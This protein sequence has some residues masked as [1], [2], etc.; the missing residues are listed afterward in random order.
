MIYPQ[1]QCAI[2]DLKFVA[3]SVIYMFF[4]FL[5]GREKGY[6]FHIT[7]KVKYE[8]KVRES[9]IIIIIIITLHF[10]FGTFISVFFPLFSTRAKDF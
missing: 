4:L 8:G 3:S 6:K 1:Q 2:L 10:G 9:I 5:Q 7:T